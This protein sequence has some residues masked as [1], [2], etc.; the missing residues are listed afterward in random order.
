ML[1]IPNSEGGMIIA[2]W[3]CW[4]YPFGVP[5]RMMHTVN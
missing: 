1:V 3:L 5:A 4:H 2:A